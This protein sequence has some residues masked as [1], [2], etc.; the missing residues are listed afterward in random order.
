MTLA[1]HLEKRRETADERSGDSTA[2]P[3]A[4][5]SLRVLPL[6]GAA[7]S[8]AEVATGDTTPSAAMLARALSLWPRLDPRAL[9]RSN[10]DPERIARLVARR[11]GLDRD[12][13][14]AMLRRAGDHE[15][16]AE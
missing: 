10:G 5:P 1:A 16:G 9:R 3:D 12:T 7:G 11:S 14:V 15:D 13:I 6:V 2:T 8:A 4:R